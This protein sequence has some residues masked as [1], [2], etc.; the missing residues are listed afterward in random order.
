MR[1]PLRRAYS[2]TTARS[3][4]SIDQVSNTPN[5]IG[6]ICVSGDA[7]SNQEVT[8]TL[9]DGVEVAENPLTCKGSIVYTVDTWSNNG[10]RRRSVN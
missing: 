3:T 1:K 5:R 9:L 6:E 7:C 4:S 8:R 10:A 2:P